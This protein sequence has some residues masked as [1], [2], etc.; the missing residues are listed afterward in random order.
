M[1]LK[2]VL[3]LKDFEENVLLQLI[4]FYNSHTSG[5]VFVVAGVSC[6]AHNY[7]VTVGLY[8]IVDID[9]CREKAGGCDQSTT[10]CINTL[11]SYKCVCKDRFVAY[12]TTICTGNTV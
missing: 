12:N 5:F 10:D 11:G 8:L 9:E 7:W 1:E 6:T 4:N 3:S 2:S